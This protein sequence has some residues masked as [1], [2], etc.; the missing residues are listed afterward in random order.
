MFSTLASIEAV[1]PVFMVVMG[2]S[3]LLFVWRLS[4]DSG[5]WASRFMLAG[6]LL[7]G[8]GYAVLL[9]MYEAGLIERYSP[10]RV[11]YEGSAAIAVGWHA[12]KLVMMNVGWLVLGTGLAMHAAILGN[13]SPAKPLKAAPVLVLSTPSHVVTH[14]SIA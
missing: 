5:V 10:R 4:K 13:P 11:H 1:R 3:M 8:F 14:E 7:L 9:P 2:V 6:A 12:V